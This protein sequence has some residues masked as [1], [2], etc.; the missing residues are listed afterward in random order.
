MEFRWLQSFITV[1]R[2]GNFTEA[3]RRLDASQPTISTHI[4]LLEE[5]LET[6]LITRTTK[7]VEVTKKGR[8]VYDYAVSIMDLR[9]RMVNCCREN[10]RTLLRVGASTIPAAYVLPSALPEYGRL[11]PETYFII[12]QSDSRGVIEGLMAGRFDVGLIGR[13]AKREGLNCEPFLRDR[14]V[15]ITPV[16]QRYIEMKAQGESPAVTGEPLILRETGADGPKS[17]DMYLAS[18]DISDG[19][20]NV[21]ARVNDQETVKNLVAKGIGISMISELAARDFALEKRVLTFKLPDYD[22]GRELYVVRPK[23]AN[24]DVLRFAEFIKRF[25]ADDAF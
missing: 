14:M 1:A 22:K 23:S 17:A 2:C 15:I 24:A 8:E 25:C 7:A 4:R 11:H 10:E 18:L 12:D 5:E 9:E 20:L 16:S 13:E 19:E 3:A 21:V 6:R